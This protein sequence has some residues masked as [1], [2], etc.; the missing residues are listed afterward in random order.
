VAY[1]ALC[2]AANFDGDGGAESTE[3]FLSDPESLLV[4]PIA[5]LRLARWPR[6]SLYAVAIDPHSG[7]LHDLWP[8]RRRIGFLSFDP[9]RAVVDVAA[10][11]FVPL[12]DL[13][14]RHKPADPTCPRD[15]LTPY[16]TV[17]CLL[18]VP[19][20]P[21]VPLLLPPDHLDETRPRYPGGWGSGVGSHRGCAV[22]PAVNGKRGGRGE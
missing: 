20:R 11:S 8:S 5:S 12:N 14:K 18:P 16:Q 10:P 15:H 2:Q 4:C 6:P 17:A 1:A 9:P 21:L 3:D 7:S 13:H 19:G 22:T